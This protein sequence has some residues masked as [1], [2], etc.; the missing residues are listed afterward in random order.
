M[1]G[2]AYV[3][4]IAASQQGAAI[5]PSVERTPVEM[6]FSVV[7]SVDFATSPTLARLCPESLRFL[8]E[9]FTSDTG[10][11]AHL[12]EGTQATWSV[13]GGQGTIANTAGTD[14]NSIIRT[15]DDLTM[16]QVWVQI[17]V[18]DH[19]VSAA[20]GYDNIGVGVCKDANNFL[21]ASVDDR[22]NLL[23]IQVK[24]AG[25]NYFLATSLFFSTA[26]PYT[27]ALSIVG[28]SCSVWYDAGSGWTV[29]PRADI[30]SY[31]DFRAADLTGWKPAFTAATA[32]NSTWVFDNLRAGRFGAVGV[33]D[34]TLVTNE[35]GS[36]HGIETDTVHFTATCAD[37]RG[38]SYAGVFSLDL[39]D[40][41]VLQTAVL[42]IER[43]GKTYED[44]ASHIV[45]RDNDDHTLLISTWGNG[46]GGVLDIR[47]ETTSANLLS[48]SHVLSATSALALPG[49]LGG[50]YGVYD[51][52]L[53]KR[54]SEWLLAY[55]ITEDT[56]FF[57]EDFYTG[58]ATSE[59]LSSWSSV[60][61]DDSRSIYE[62]PKGC[63]ANGD[64]WITVGGRTNSI[65][66]NEAM[67]Y[68]GTLDF[69]LDAP[70]GSTQP[71]A[72]IFPYGS[73]FLLLT[74][75]DDR[76][77]SQAFSWGRLV[78]QESPRYP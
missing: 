65:V 55:S 7:A 20:S 18:V 64:Y 59:D 50:S 32:T 12:T 6:E 44:H 17:D 76:F 70:S 68:Q 48:G 39:T 60:D 15:G 24:N 30:G 69:E 8:H 67:V 5:A 29:G 46:F 25:I 11:F 19:P 72:Q 62:G 9:Q 45:V 16:P 4:A 53:V 2:A 61:E 63:L 27:L 13:S 77:D 40:Y 21:F 58:A 10:Q 34:V 51:P 66:Y 35:D 23:R 37:G 38:K 31:F 22:N 56:D 78:V 3:G 36:P 28:N 47:M 41:S 26:A 71:H 74:H 43:D 73:S 49:D 14:R 52:Y 54:G 42:M 57:P 33:R 1:I 75:T